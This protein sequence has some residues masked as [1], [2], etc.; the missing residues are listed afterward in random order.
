MHLARCCYY[1]PPSSVSLKGQD[2]DILLD[3]SKNI[4]SEKTMQL[5]FK[6][7]SPSVNCS[8]TNKPRQSSSNGGYTISADASN[9]GLLL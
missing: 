5:L 6:L 7:V 9:T 2:G 8:E 1:L 3:Y 4:V